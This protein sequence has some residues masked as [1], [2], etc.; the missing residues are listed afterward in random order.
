MDCAAEGGYD[1]LVTLLINSK[2]DVDPTDKTRVRKF[3]QLLIYL[4]Q[5]SLSLSLSLSLC[6]NTYPSPSTI[7]SITFPSHHP[8]GHS[9]PNCIS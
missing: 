4:H 9:P 2:A 7:S 3:Y 8:S 1:E 6:F 5:L